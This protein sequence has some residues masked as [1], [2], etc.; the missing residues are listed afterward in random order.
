MDSVVTAIIAKFKIRAELGKAK[1][2]TDMDRTDLSVL[3]WI[4]HAQ[5]EH[6][7]AIVYLEKLKKTLVG[8]SSSTP[9]HPCRS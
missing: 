3:D 6:M 4:N 1:Y 5:E 8:I 7:D 9:S 2:G